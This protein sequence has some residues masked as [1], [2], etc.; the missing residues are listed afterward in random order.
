MDATTGWL[1][2]IEPK[3]RTWNQGRC[4]LNAQ[5]GKC[6]RSR[7]Q[8][9]TGWIARNLFSRKRTSTKN[10]TTWDREY[11]N[12]NIKDQLQQCFR[13][14]HRSNQNPREQSSRYLDTQTDPCQRRTLHH[15]RAKRIRRKDSRGW[16]P[17]SRIRKWHIQHPAGNGSLLHQTDTVGCPRH[18]SHRCSHLV[19]Q[20]SDH[21]WL[22]STGD[23]R[24]FRDRYKRRTPPGHWTPV[25]SGRKLHR[26]RPLPR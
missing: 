9:R 26:Q 21:Q 17:D 7:S 15:S 24:I 10:A 4:P 18:L 16:R 14:L 19:R 5:Q 25:A 1:R 3:N 13:L 12:T 2:N 11:W 8:R 22:S 20:H 6:H 23:Q